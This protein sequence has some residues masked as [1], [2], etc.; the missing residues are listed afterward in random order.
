[1]TV[2]SQASSGAGT[3][4]EQCA[5]S[6][7]PLEV[8]HF[9]RLPGPGMYSLER[10]FAD[11]RQALPDG[12][13]C[14]TF[15]A[16]YPSRGFWRRVLN[17]LEAP[18]HQGMVNHVTGDVTY[19]ALLLRKRRTLLT[20]H[21]CATLERPAGW[22]RFA[23]KM[24]WFDLPIRR[25][26]LVSVISQATKQELLR[27]VHCPAEKVRVVHCC[28]SPMYQPFPK[29][30]NPER[31]VLLQVGTT[32][33]KNLARVAEALKGIPAHLRIVGPL[34]AEQEEVLRANAVSFEAKG[35]LTE[36]E[37]LQ[38]YRECDMLV[39][40]STYEGFGLPIV[41]AQATGRP[42]ITSNLL[43]MPE[44]AGD[45]A[46]LVNPYA[47]ESIRA[48]VLRVIREKDYREELVRRGFENVKRFQ[49]REI[50]AQ[51]AQL[52]RELASGQAGKA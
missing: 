42:V 17:L 47:P 43:S 39:F 21:D 25:V 3:G 22:R 30:F 50:A 37:L 41:E 38:A 52:Y 15:V 26:G 34:S 49:P 16:R 29:A 28:V 44:V 18:F 11:V 45:A 33:N 13:E 48:G 8:V 19:L 32:Y 14:R 6:T 35:G 10:L 23:I 1:M 2:S 36:A 40:A 27:H 46:C 51:Y 4:I 20:I 9:Q 31:P 7:L 5:A 24:L 12:V